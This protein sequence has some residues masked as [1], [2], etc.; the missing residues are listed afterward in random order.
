MVYCFGW[1]YPV[2]TKSRI[3]CTEN[4]STRVILS[5]EIAAMPK[6]FYGLMPP[7]T[8]EEYLKNAIVHPVHGR[9]TE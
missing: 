5:E 7:Q 3:D 2:S 4:C 6:D 9:R 8:V 1:K